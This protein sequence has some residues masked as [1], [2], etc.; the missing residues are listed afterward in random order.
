VNDEETGTID[1]FLIKSRGKEMNGEL[2]PVVVAREA[3]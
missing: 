3:C 2:I 1:G